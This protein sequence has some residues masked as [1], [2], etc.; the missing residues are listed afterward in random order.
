[1]RFWVLYFIGCIFGL[2]S[3]AVTIRL[4]YLHYTEE[5]HLTYPEFFLAHPWEFAL[6]GGCSVVCLLIKRG[7]L[8]SMSPR[9]PKGLGKS[10]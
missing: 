10:P 5:R 2:G 8:R 9:G 3:L 7:G 4:S 1:M 6:A